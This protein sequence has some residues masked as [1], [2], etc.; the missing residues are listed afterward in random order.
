[1]G[2]INNTVDYLNKLEPRL[3]K[4]MRAILTKNR[5]NASYRLYNSFFFFIKKVR[6]GIELEFQY[7]KHG[8]YVLDNR[9]KV[10]AN[11]P[12]RKGGYSAIH[13]I[14]RWILA[15]GISIGQGKIR[16]VYKEG[17]KNVSTQR[18]KAKSLDK[19]LTSFAYAIWFNIKKQGRTSTPS[20]N[21]L[22]PYENLYKQQTFKRGLRQA[23]VKDGWVIIGN[24]N[25]KN[26]TTIK[27]KT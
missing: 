2:Q 12:S 13:S 18:A 14:K 8:K 5:R 22:K 10:V 1:M 11:K 3:R 24:I 19:K 23:L 16:S 25:K 4:D 17:G 9:R 21:F 20:T 6:T 15:K 27:I 7:A 26:P